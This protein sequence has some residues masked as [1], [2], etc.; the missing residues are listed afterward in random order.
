M[1]SVLSSSIVFAAVTTKTLAY[2]L[3]E[4][5]G[6][7]VRKVTKDKT[8]GKTHGAMASGIKS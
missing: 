2:V 6:K 5:T 3:S 8:T 4:L 1:V 7:T